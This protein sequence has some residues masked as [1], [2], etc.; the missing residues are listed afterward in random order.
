MKEVEFLPPDVAEKWKL[1]DHVE[2]RPMPAFSTE[3]LQRGYAVFA[4]HWSELI[5]PNTAPRE[6]ELNPELTILLLA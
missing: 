4:R 6:N 3:D 2:T 5:D 1:T